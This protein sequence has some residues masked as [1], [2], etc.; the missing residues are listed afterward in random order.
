MLTK[1]IGQ[2]FMNLY[3]VAKRWPPVIVEKSRVL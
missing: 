1:F 3:Q 2:P